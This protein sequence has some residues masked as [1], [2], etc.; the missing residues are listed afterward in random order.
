MPRTKRPFTLPYEPEYT[1]HRTSRRQLHNSRIKVHVHM[2]L[3][4]S[5][6]IAPEAPEH[7]PPPR[8][9]RVRASA[10]NKAELG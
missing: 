9:R 5:P 4:R 10:R 3:L 2:N 8:P 7:D 1:A 6:S